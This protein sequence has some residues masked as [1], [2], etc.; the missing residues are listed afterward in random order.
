MTTNLKHELIGLATTAA[1]FALPVG[2]AFAHN[3]WA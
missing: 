1:L 3:S 2:D